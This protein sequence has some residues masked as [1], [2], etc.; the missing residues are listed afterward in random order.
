LR[1][2]VFRIKEVLEFLDC[3]AM[4]Y[5]VASVEKELLEGKAAKVEML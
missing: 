4:S 2:L 5:G 3:T 1:K